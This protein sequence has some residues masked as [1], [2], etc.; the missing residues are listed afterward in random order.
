MLPLLAVPG[1]GGGAAGRITEPA[2][3]W[4]ANPEPQIPA[5]SKPD[6]VRFRISNEPE[7]I[8]TGANFRV[9]TS[10][11]PDGKTLAFTETNPKRD[12]DIWVV[13][14]EGSRQAR[15]YLQTPFN[16]SSA[17]FSPDGNWMAYTSDEPGTS[18]VCVARF[19]DGSGKLQISTDGGIAPR[20]AADA[21]E[22]F[23]RKCSLRR[24][25]HDHRALSAVSLQ[26]GASS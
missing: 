7:T 24:R 19:S 4:S 5:M 9:P 26:R 15:P 12:T 11:S 17:V 1:S 2:R 18:Q 3:P 20:W 10:F 25:L 13:T 8:L 6:M 22:L 14:L 23:Y 16:E 21:R